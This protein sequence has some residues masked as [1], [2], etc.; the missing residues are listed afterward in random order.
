MLELY[1]VDKAPDMMEFL[2]LYHVEHSMSDGY[3]PTK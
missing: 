1:V 3:W 2:C